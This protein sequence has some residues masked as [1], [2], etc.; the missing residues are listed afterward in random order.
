MLTGVS[1]GSVSGP[2]LLLYYIND[3]CNS[4]EKLSFYSFSDDTN[5]LYAEI[6]LK[7]LEV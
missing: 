6:D 1:Q 2:V 4:S 3:T 5:L 7:L